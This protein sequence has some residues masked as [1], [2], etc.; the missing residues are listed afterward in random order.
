MADHDHG[1]FAV[2]GPMIDDRT[3]QSAAREARNY[4]WRI[5]G[6]RLSRSAQAGWCAARRRREATAMTKTEEF[7]AKEGT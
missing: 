6:S 1:V 7:D 2:E 3:W 5:A 4:H